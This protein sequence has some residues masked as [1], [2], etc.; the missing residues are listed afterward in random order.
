MAA[1]ECS[2]DWAAQYPEAKLKEPLDAVDDLLPLDVGKRRPAS[3]LGL[4]ADLVFLLSLTAG[5]QLAHQLNDKKYNEAEAAS[6][7]GVPHVLVI[8]RAAL[9]VVADARQAAPD[10]EAREEVA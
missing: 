3:A 5:H 2:L 6:Q 1:P 10:V 4:K 7:D 9:H 8:I